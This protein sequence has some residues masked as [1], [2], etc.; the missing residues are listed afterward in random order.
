MRP[1]PALLSATFGTAAVIA[2]TL[3]YWNLAAAKAPSAPGRG[4][5]LAK[6]EAEKGEWSRWRGPNGDGISQEKGLLT[7][8]PEEGPPLLWQAKGLG[9]GMSSVAVKGGRIF[10]L[11]Q[12]KGKTRL[13]AA[14]VKDGEILFSTEVGS[15]SD[16]NCT[17]TVDG[18]LVFTVTHGGDL[19]CVNAESGQ[20]VWQKNFRTDFGGKMMSG[21]G[22][23]ES[24]LVDGDRVIVTPGSTEALLV[25]LDRKT[26]EKIWESAA[27]QMPGRKG[28][29]GAG[30]ASVVISHAADVKQYITLAGRGIVSVDAVS[31]KLLWS[32]NDVANGTANIPTPIVS[33]DYVFCSSGYRDGGTALLKIVKDGSGLKVNEEYYFAAN[34]MQNHHGGM[35]LLGDHVYMG[36]GHSNG[37][38]LCVDLKTGKDAWRPGRGEGS[39]SAAIA[40]ADGHLYFRYDDATMVLI[41][42]NPKEYLVKG[43]FT[44][45]TKNGKS[46]PH[47]VIAGGKLYLRDQDVLNC[48]DVKKK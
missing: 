4:P 26:G 32:Y 25:A 7:E 29:D 31:G 27:P 22:Y 1:V 8:W 36:H 41:E 12:L 17:P 5:D 43:K 18:D 11:G 15:G 47:P 44:I 14:S 21:W 38:P 9:K 10:T 24:P 23:S 19:A 34:E 40:Y 42:A 28:K 6:V 37:F 30:Y 20:L 35:I 3:G 48:Y 46:W 16:P 2:A 39:G 13:V 33:G 45:A